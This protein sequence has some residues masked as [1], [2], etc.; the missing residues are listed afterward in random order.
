MKFNGKT[1]LYAFLTWFVPLLTS[2]FLYDQENDVYLP[3]FAAFKTLMLALLFG[4][5]FLSYKRIK[6][7]NF[8][9]TSVAL[10]FTAV[11]SIFDMVVLII[12]FKMDIFM[13][14]A[15]I[16]PFCLVSFFGIGY[17]VLKPETKT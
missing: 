15:A 13:W 17:M 3:S 9:W 8:K 12:E 10:L 14:L 2:M 5:T 7:D 1:Y 6:K 11:Y 16:F 4:L